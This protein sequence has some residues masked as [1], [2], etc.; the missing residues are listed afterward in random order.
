MRERLSFEH[1]IGLLVPRG[2]RGPQ[3]ERERQ[4]SGPRT[5]VRAL[6]KSINKWRVEKGQTPITEDGLLSA[7]TN[8]AVQEFQ[9]DSALKREDGIARPATRER[10]ALLLRILANIPTSVVF[11]T[12]RDRLFELLGSAGFRSLTESTQTLVLQRILSYQRSPGS[13][14]NIPRLM[15]LVIE[16]GFELLPTSSQDL[17]LRALAARPADAELVDNLR[18]LAGSVQFRN[19]QGATQI[20]VLKRIESY[21]GDRRKI[22]NLE[23]LITLTQRFAEL[24]RQSRNVMLVALA[25]RPDDTRLV[26]NFRKAAER[27]GLQ[28]PPL[29]QPTQT[30][31][32]NRVRDLPGGPG[33]VDNLMNLLTTPGFG[34]LTEDVRHQVLDGLPVFGDG[35]LS[36]T[37]IE[38]IMKLATASGYGKLRPEVRGFMLEVLAGRPDKRE[39]ADALRDLADTPRFRHDHRM[40]RKTILQVADS[41]P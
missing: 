18:H 22:D 31:V 26:E 41:I 5:D 40:A 39:L 10:L 27:I 3:A 8:R 15:N 33:G 20:W 23:K 16:S 38:N 7:D 17:M 34:D 4:A 1:E 2:R 28:V 35:V 9:S 36:S 30:D 13:L 14:D 37:Q 25:N 19:L 6:Q 12:D 21:A 32:F 29:D 11:S 24:S